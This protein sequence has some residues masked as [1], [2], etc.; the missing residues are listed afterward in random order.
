[1]A[2]FRTPAGNIHPAVKG[3]AGATA[4][5]LTIAVTVVSSFEG[6]ASKPYK[7]LVG[8]GQPETWC[9]G[10]TKAD[11]PPPPYSK[12]FTKAQCQEYLGDDLQKYDAMVRKCVHV[13]LPPHREAALVSAVYNLGPGPLC[14]GPI[15]RYLNAGNVRVACDSLLG[16]DHARGRRLPGLT[17]RRQEERALCLRDD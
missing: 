10:M 3:A 16:F 2:F 5:W 4:V 17:R 11:G 8:T 12:V 6:F 1:M 9:Y 14:H 7:D 15:G 13:T